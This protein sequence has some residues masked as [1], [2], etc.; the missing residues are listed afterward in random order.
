M[1][2]RLLLNISEASAMLARAVV[3]Y[4]VVN[5]NILE[6]FGNFWLNCL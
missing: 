4:V 1:P 3:V 5:I 2:F 6:I